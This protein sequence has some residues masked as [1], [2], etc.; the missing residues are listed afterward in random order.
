M[1]NTRMG[2]EQQCY[3]QRR[4]E[5]DKKPGMDVISHKSLS[6][7]LKEYSH[8]YQPWISMGVYSIDHVSYRYILLG[9]DIYP[10]LGSISTHRHA[11]RHLA[12]AICLHEPILAISGVECVA[13]RN[14]DDVAEKSIL[15]KDIYLPI[16][17]LIEI[18][19]RKAFW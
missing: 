12:I 16:K 5:E 11:Y 14:F 7:S 9:E 6:K 10:S 13:G 8:C 3:D 18:I 4:E 2:D 17:N 1:L 19:L 15:Q